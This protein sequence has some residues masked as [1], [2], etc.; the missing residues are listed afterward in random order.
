MATP[1][2]GEVRTFGFGTI[3]KGWAVCNGQLLSVSGNQPLFSL[4]GTTYGGD[5]RNNFAL[6]NLQG[7]FPIG[8]GND[9]NQG[10]P[11]GETNHTLLPNE[12][13]THDHSVTASSAA[14]TATPAAGN[15]PASLAGT[16]MYAA[17]PNTSLDGGSSPT[18]GQAHANQPPYLAVSFCIAVVGIFPSRN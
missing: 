15:Y 8:F 12:L 18:G 11:G 6:P 14:P 7:S 16:S 9:Y 3:P 5:G 4:I 13:P 10:Q 2:I 1:F 17:A